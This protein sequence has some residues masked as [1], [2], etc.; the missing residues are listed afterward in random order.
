MLPVSLTTRRR[1]RRA[2]KLA[3]L[4][5]SL[6]DTARL[7]RRVPPRRSLRASLGGAR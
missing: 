5:V 1:E 3:R 7:A 6:D 2:R 4:F